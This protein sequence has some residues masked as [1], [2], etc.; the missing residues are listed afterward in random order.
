MALDIG[1]NERRRADPGESSYKCGMDTVLAET[2]TTDGFL[3]WDDKQEA[4]HEFDGQHIILMTGGS[5]A[6]QRIVFNLCLLLMG[7]L[8]KHPL[9]ALHE[10]RIRI[11]TIVRYPDVVVCATPLEQTMRTLTDAAAIFRRLR[12]YGSGGQAA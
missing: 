4:K 5:V 10:I 6:H 12:D 1:V 11:G 8:D 7:L 3:A 9:T 2:W